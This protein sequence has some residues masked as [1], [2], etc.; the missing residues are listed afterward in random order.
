[1]TLTNTKKSSL[2][3]C[4]ALGAAVAAGVAG[5]G[6]SPL[7]AAPAAGVT[8]S[9]G[10]VERGVTRPSEEHKLVFA[11]P[12]VIGKVLVKDGDPVKAGQVIAEQDDAVERAQMLQAEAKLYAAELQI[13]AAEADLAQKQVELGRKKAIY[14]DLIDQ[15]KTNSELDE[16]MVAVKIG[17]IAVKYR[18][19][20]R[21]AEQLEMDVLKVKIQQKKLIS[22]IDGLVARVDVRTGEGADMTKPAVVVVNNTPLW[23]EVNVP[24][25][26]A[27]SLQVSQSLAVKYTDEDQW[28]QGEILVKFPV[29]DAG[30]NVQRVR[31]QLANESRRESGIPVVVKLPDGS[32]AAARADR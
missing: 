31:L 15:G 22:P 14:R 4:L 17:E 1:M 7:T 29:A 26:K 21:V 30:A 19:Q 16:A 18:K 2:I 12:G 27:R 5:V 20:E 25:V 11:G 9:M 23:V 3:G 28:Q 24:T 8:A 10:G 32:A 13:G 6:S